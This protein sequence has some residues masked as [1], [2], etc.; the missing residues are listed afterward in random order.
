MVLIS[1]E[2]QREARER[3]SR[4]LSSEQ[5]VFAEPSSW[6][7]PPMALVAGAGAGKTECLLARFEWY[8]RNEKEGAN[9]QIISFSNSAA[10]TFQARF[11]ASWGPRSFKVARTLHSWTKTE[12]L[13]PHC[14]VEDRVSFIFP[15]AVA[16]LDGWTG[17]LALAESHTLLVDEAQDCDEEQW[18]IF[19]NLTRFGAKVVIT[20]DPRQ[21][22]Y[23][24][25]G[26]SPAGMLEFYKGI[27]PARLTVNR[28]SSRGI[29]E[30]AN[31]IVACS[32]PECP[33][34]GM[35]SERPFPQ[36]SAAETP[37]ELVAVHHVRSLQS[38]HMAEAIHAT[39][40]EPRSLPACVLTWRNADVEKLHQNLSLLGYHCLAIPSSANG[41]EEIA[42]SRCL[43]SE[44]GKADL[45]HIRSVHSCKGDGYDTVLFHLR[46]FACEVEALEDFSRRTMEERQEELRLYYVA[47]TRAKRRL[48]ILIQGAVA[49]V[50]WSAISK[51]AP[52]LLKVGASFRGTWGSR[53]PVDAD[54]GI[55]VQ[56]LCAS[57][58]AADC[59]LT[60]LPRAQ[61]RIA[62][63][64]QPRGGLLADSGERLRDSQPTSAPL[65][66]LSALRV[67]F[68]HS[69]SVQFV[70][71]FALA[72]SQMLERIRDALDFMSL[73]PL[74]SAQIQGL[75][76]LSETDPLFADALGAR[77]GE[78]LQKPT[79]EA[80]ESLER[81]LATAFRKLSARPGPLPPFALINAEV[82][83]ELLT[84]TPGNP[85]LIGAQGS[86]ALG[87]AVKN[88]R[89]HKD[90]HV[91]IAQ[92]FRKRVTLLDAASLAECRG[93]LG[94]ECS[95]L[96]TD[97]ED[98]A[99]SVGA[100]SM[101]CEITKCRVEGI[102]ASRALPY[103]SSA[104]AHDLALSLEDCIIS[105][106]L[107]EQ[108]LGQA[109]ALR[110]RLGAWHTEE[111]LAQCAADLPVSCTA[112]GAPGALT[113]SIHLFVPAHKGSGTSVFVSAKAQIS[114]EDEAEALVSAGIHAAGAAHRVVI[115][116]T[117]SARVFV[118]EIAESEDIVGIAIRKWCGGSP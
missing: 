6:T 42:L 3:A 65:P 45:V 30:L 57:Y 2:L 26:A 32:V 59:L 100:G 109:R 43:S 71:K 18:R 21:A 98:C 25:N 33:V 41:H 103:L 104:T 58:V 75:E 46:G 24:W 11:E 84:T 80:F 70:F 114:L 61:R 97:G 95:R 27:E 56:K 69:A 90:A 83:R 81:C 54:A 85:F 67:S 102:S 92:L 9:L 76:R 44:H 118:Y 93:F 49:P 37:S 72:R 20:G 68:L 106:D 35:E 111:E 60:Y 117:G 14:G 64:D 96:L 110:K 31:A 91:Q 38:S 52:S 36:T 79:D 5:M 55:T 40:R 4:R 19:A 29:V 51:A 101:L 62:C 73:V 74:T 48:A 10:D 47:V 108:C 94:S 63:A 116:E 39:M 16:L 105:H 1:A 12:L 89:R 28:R 17:P 112:S 86:S 88:L 78:C 50:W 15:Q 113:G 34:T 22:I 77:L 53:G 99:S 13:M 8:L 115:V 66:R 82:F 7:D 107:Y 23:S 87:R